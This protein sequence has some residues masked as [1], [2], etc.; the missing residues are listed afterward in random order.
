MLIK[1]Y[2]VKKID[3]LHMD[4]EGHDFRIINS[5]D[6]SE[7]KPRM[8]QYENIHLSDADKKKCVSILKRHGYKVLPR[9][10]D[11]FAYLK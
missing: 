8:I 2:K 3:M 6:F 5:I 10:Y 7:I 9:F 1:K 11:T 4:T